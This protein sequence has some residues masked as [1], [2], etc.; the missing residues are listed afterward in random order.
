M[1]GTFE[2]ALNFM[3]AHQL[4]TYGPHEFNAYCAEHGLGRVP[5]APAISVDFS[6]RLSSEL[7]SS[8]TMVFRLGRHGGT[9]TAFGLARSAGE[10]V[11]EF[12]VQDQ[13]CVDSAERSAFQPSAPSTALRPFQLLPKLTET[14]LVNLAVGSGLLHR[15]LGLDGVGTPV[16]ATGQS[17]MTFDFR[18]TA[19][20]GT[21]THRSGQVEIDAM[22]TARCHGQETLFLIEAKVGRPDGDLA[23]H[24]LVYPY[25]G[26]RGTVP[27]DMAIVP[28][29][30]KSWEED[31]VRHF[32]IVECRLPERAVPVVA[33]LVP[34]R[35]RWW[36]LPG[37]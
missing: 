12:F 36:T 23:K 29:Y 16:P 32:L 27:A 9:G 35:A 10:T 25:A 11:Q 15:S 20:A 30:L 24:K 34:F 18:P 5:T 7:R 19:R 22:F 4:N 8:G 33:E 6:R 3:A 31:G 21:W 13:E 26:L 37:F 17:T 14:S 1:T 2:P 28:I